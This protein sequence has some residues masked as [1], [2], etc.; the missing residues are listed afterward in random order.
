MLLYGD[1][2]THTIYSHGKGT[3]KDNAEAAKQK[4]LKEIAITDHGLKHIAFGLRKQKIEK[5]KKDIKEFGGGQGVK[6]LLGIEANI[7]GAD[8]QIDMNDEQMGQFDVI[9]CGYHKFIFPKS[10]SDA[11]TFFAPNIIYDFFGIRSSKKRIETNT[12]AVINCINRFPVDVLTHINYG[13]KVN[14][15]EIAK[16]CAE[17]GTFVEINGKRI[18]YTDQ[19]MQ[20]MLDAG[21]EFIVNSD[22]HTP[23]RVG[24]VELC[25]KIIE[26]LNI[27]RSRIVN[28]SKAPDW[29]SHA[30]RKNTH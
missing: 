15:G 19:E 7:I 5:L 2:H 29:R 10:P 25:Q 6:I 13:L 22:A 17:R 4:G 9:L 24:N 14:C 1:Y 20:D 3:V 12:R 8:G 27:P 11:F 26:R 23:E 18:T 30:A 16:V 21:A 28:F